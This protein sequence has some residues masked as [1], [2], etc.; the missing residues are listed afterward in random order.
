MIHVTTVC[1][2]WMLVTSD[3][4]GVEGERGDGVEG[5]MGDGVEGERGE[6]VKLSKRRRRRRRRVREEVPVCP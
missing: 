6:K 2:D 1:D 4:E 5:E 3:R